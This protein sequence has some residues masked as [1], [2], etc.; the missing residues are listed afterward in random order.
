LA[1][2][3]RT[4]YF[5]ANYV[6]NLPRGSRLLGDHWLSRAVFDNWAISGISSVATGNPAELALT[7][8]GQDA[9]SRLLGAYSNGNLSG[10]Q[11][12]ILVTGDPQGKPNEIN[13]AAFTVPGINDIGPYPRNYLRNPGF[14]THDLSIL[15]NFPVA[16]E[17]R[18][19][20]Q[21]RVEMFN[22]LNHTQYSGVNRTTN[23]TNSANQT[24]GA[25]FN[26][27]TG[28]KVT[29]NVRPSGSASVLGSFFGEYNAARDPRI[30]QVAVKL[31][32]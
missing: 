13:L 28:L 23:I 1:N 25:I 15:K 29:N 24:G 4:H 22:F 6:W 8:T 2:F 20:L 9:G 26:N 31:Y 12:R 17:G 5:V 27:Y 30:I 21:F 3:D 14:N 10:Q 16:R 19:Y 32:F 18:S 7:I 11:P